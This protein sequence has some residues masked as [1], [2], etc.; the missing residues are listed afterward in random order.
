LAA[1]DGP[2]VRSAGLL[3]PLADW[4]GTAAMLGLSVL[5]VSGGAFSPFLY[6]RF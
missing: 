4:G 5:Q 3:R 2:K 6:F 1:L